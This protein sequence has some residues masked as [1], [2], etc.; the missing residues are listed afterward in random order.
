MVRQNE[1]GGVLGGTHGGH[2]LRLADQLPR[3][4]DELRLAMERLESFGVLIDQQSRLRA[5][6]SALEQGITSHDL[7]SDSDRVTELVNAIEIAEDFGAIS[8]SLP[9]THEAE[10][11]HQLRRAVAGSLLSA[12]DDREPYR[13]QSQFWMGTILDSAGLHP[14]LP[15]VTDGGR[16][17]DFI[18]QPLT[19]KY[20]AEVKRPM[21]EHNIATNVEKAVSQLEALGVE[22][23]V[24]VDVSDC[25]R[26][27]P[28]ERYRNEVE[29]LANEIDDV[30]WD[31]SA[32]RHRGRFRRIFLVAAYARGKWLKGSRGSPTLWRVNYFYP[33]LL[34]YQHNRGQNL[35][36]L[37]ANQIW[38][39]MRLAIAGADFEVTG[40]RR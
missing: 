11:R 19:T 14:T 36:T 18:I 16:K 5:A 32:N 25:L 34:T 6:E 20:G 28:V 4:R 27:V 21:H 30:L 26:Q 22:G 40:G 3:L 12:D 17:P 7:E 8:R 31:S 9:Q 39:A 38:N 24:T 33:T 23:L 35:T 15:I 29:R 2:T 10:T 13:Y 37:A 1:S